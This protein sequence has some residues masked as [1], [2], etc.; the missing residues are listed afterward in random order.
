MLAAPP[1]LPTPAVLDR[2]EGFL[3]EL[4][5]ALDPAPSAASPARGRPPI[6][7]GVLLWSGLLVCVLRGLPSQLALWRLLSGGGLWHFPKVAVSDD[8]VYKRLERHG[9][10]AM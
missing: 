4:V 3:G 8:A 7:P 9:E 10:A 1:A 2:L 5:A 6:L